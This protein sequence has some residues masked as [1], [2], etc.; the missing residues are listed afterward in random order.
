LRALSALG[1]ASATPAYTEEKPRFEAAPFPL[2]VASGYPSQDGV[3]IWTR[4]VI[5]PTRGDGGIDPVR[6]RLNWEVA[7]DEK[8]QNVVAQG[9][10]Y[11]VP[12]WAHSARIE[13]KGLEP[14]RWYWY[15]FIA[16]NEV[17]PIGRTRTAPTHKDVPK[18]LRF[19]FASG[20]H[21]EQGYF[22]SYRHMLADELDLVVFVGDYIHGSAAQADAVRKHT[23]LE[24]VTLNDYRVRHALYKEDADLRAAHAALPW[25]MTW[26]D[27]EVH[28]GYA[29]D[30]PDSNLSPEQFLAR[31]AAAYRAYYEHL[32]LRDRMRPNGA[33]MRLYVQMGWG[34][35]ARF[36]VLD[37]RQ[38]RSPQACPQE[39]HRAGGNVV[40][41][42]E[43]REL[44]N[45]IRTLLGQQQERWLEEA[46]ELS[47]ARWNVLAQPLLMAQ[48]DRKS[49]RGRKAWTDGWDGYPQSRK[50][51]LAFLQDKK[52]ANPVVI[53]GGGHAFGVA[54][55][56]RHFDPPL[57]KLVASEFSG[58]SLTSVLSGVGTGDRV[59][60]LLPKNPHVKFADAR[61]R[62]YVRVEVTPSQ[63]RAD[64]RAMQSVKEREASCSTLAT[65]AVADGKPGPQRV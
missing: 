18:R 13:V 47:P 6:I 23:G 46:L 36:F 29:G 30:L 48:F 56:R 9:L 60:D 61:Y 16:G 39:G 42:A 37:G 49:G 12:A 5:D 25:V 33:A 20:Q 4:L 43:C 55:L 40:D 35:L 41:V 8:M 24:P 65:F 45:S 10:E 63:W 19:A 32:P 31:R 62:G 53:G 17:S 59:N 27:E 22:N 14:D 50:R 52:V 26:N 58:T 1:M 7:S 15:R 54:D 34:S 64:L 44:E 3:V 2:G 51:L 57:S 21:Y 28:R 11:L 38:Y